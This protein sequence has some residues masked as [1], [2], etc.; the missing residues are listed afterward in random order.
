MFAKSNKCDFAKP[1][2]EYLGHIISKEGVAS[3]PQKLISRF[4]RNY[5]DFWDSWAIIEDLF[6]IMV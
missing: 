5:G 3:D 6:E 4:I 1:M 2:V